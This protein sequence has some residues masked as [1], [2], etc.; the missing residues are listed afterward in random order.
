MLRRK[1]L[2][3]TDAGD[4]CS[5]SSHIMTQPELTEF[6]AELLEAVADLET[7]SI[8]AVVRDD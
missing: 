8:E 6:E 1:T 4:N 7:D 5:R 2:T 3:L